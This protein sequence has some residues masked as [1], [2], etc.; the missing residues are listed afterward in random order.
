MTTLD[1]DKLEQNIQ[2]YLRPESASS[3]DAQGVTNPEVRVRAL[4][5]QVLS[6]FL[7]DPRLLFAVAG[8]S[9][10]VRRDQLDSIFEDLTA[11]RGLLR[12]TLRLVPPIEDIGLLQQAAVAATQLQQSGEPSALQRVLVPTTAHLKKVLPTLLS[13]GSVA[14]APAEARLQAAQLW[15]SIKQ[16]V[17]AFIEDVRPLSTLLESYVSASLPA[18][19]GA[20][21]RERVALSL[22]SLVERLEGQTPSGRLDTAEQDTIDLLAMRAALRSTSALP[23]PR[24]FYVTGTLTASEDTSHPSNPATTTSL[25]APYEINASLPLY[26]QVGSRPQQQLSLSPSPQPSFEGLTP[27]A[28][29][30]AGTVTSAVGP[31][32]VGSSTQELQLFLRYTGGTRRDATALIPIGSALTAASIALSLNDQWA[33][34]EISGIS[35]SDV[36]GALQVSFS[37]GELY[38]GSGGA[39]SALGLTPSGGFRLTAGGPAELV[40]GVGPFTITAGVNDLLL[41]HALDQGTRQW[42]LVRVTLPAGTSSA[43]SLVTLVQ[44]ALSAEGLASHY[45]AQTSSGAVRVYSL[46]SGSS[47]GLRGAAGSA[48][49]TVGISVSSSSLG[50]D[51]T[52]TL[53]MTLEGILPLTATLPAGVYSA[54]TVARLL[55]AQL[56][57]SWSCQATGPYGAQTVSIRYVAPGSSQSFATVTETGLSRLL[58][59]PAGYVSRGAPLS[60]RSLA[61]RINTQNLGVGATA[62]LN[63]PVNVVVALTGDPLIAAVGREAGFAALSSPGA[64]T[65]RLVVTN[66]LAQVGDRVRLQDDSYWTVTAVTSSY[67]QA[68]GDFTPATST[69]VGYVV[70]PALSVAAGSQLDVLEGALAGSYDVD[71]SLDD[72]KVRLVDA[73]PVGAGEAQGSGQ[74]GV[75]VVR[76][77]AASSGPLA[78]SGAGAN[79]LLGGSRNVTPTTPWVL[80]AQAPVPPAPGDVL[81]AYL[82]NAVSPTSTTAVEFV[83]G[84]WLR[85]TTPLLL[86]TS[87]SDAS[88]APFGR[89]KSTAY[90][91]L[92]ALEE[93]LKAALEAEILTPSAD[94]AVVALTTTVHPTQAQLLRALER[95]DVLQAGLS[96]LRAGLDSFTQPTSPTLETL[97]KK[98]RDA[99][100]DRAEALLLRGD[101]VSF[102]ALDGSGMTFTGVLTSGLRTLVADRLPMDGRLQSEEPRVYE[103]FQEDDPEEVT[104]VDESRSVISRPDSLPGRGVTRR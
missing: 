18:I 83:E 40:S 23:T 75:G 9:A 26:A 86:G 82:S 103:R 24:K 78:L 22:G 19:A 55:G 25:P 35:A 76:L 64:S 17:S 36:A 20:K 73:L 68:V 13:K 65:L 8:A 60:A 84:R 96:A 28:F 98:L 79:L 59:L 94:N 37:G 38:L 47:Y 81:E 99:G 49:A 11:L 44:S 12:A 67:F 27:E 39:N 4:Q 89:I 43:A 2:R 102:F 51:D 15:V 48:N 54:R 46:S 45:A 34:Q 100:A 91:Q 66:T 14:P 74:L 97:R 87:Y 53:L 92:N 50:T 10:Q 31:F 71:A 101:I 52:R 1:Q 41:L 95:L 16:D 72:L 77:T 6:A 69:R 88:V 30:D 42:S 5:E 85:V 56:G 33:L 7:A 93:A 29:A 80:C 57:G 3:Q 63:N 32:T 90:V 58:A 21:T 104:Q 70:G 61:R 62:E